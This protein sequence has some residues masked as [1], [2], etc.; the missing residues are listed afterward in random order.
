MTGYAKSGRTENKV[1]IIIV[2]C[3]KIGSTLA[4][5][6]NEVG[7]D[8]VVIDQSPA[9]VKE[10]ASKYDLMGVIGNGATRDTLKEAGVDS[11]HLV[12]AVTGSDELNLLCCVMAKKKSGCAAI[13]RVKNP[14]YS[15]DS[16]YLKEELELGLVIN[17][18]YSA[19]EEIARLLKFPMAINIES[20][21]KGKVDLIRYRLTENSALIG[22]S[23]KEAMIKFRSEVIV[24]TV[25]RGEDVF[26]PK[27]DFVFAEK[28]VISFAATQKSAAAF[29]SK[30]NR[31]KQES[32]KSATIIG[33]GVTTHYLLEL[34][35]RSGIDIKV[36][37]KNP[38]I[39]DE[40]STKFDNVTVICANPSDE[41]VLIEE[42]VLKTDA[43]ISLTDLDEENILLSLFAKNGGSNKVITKINKIEY[44]SVIS[45][46]ELDSI[47]YPKNIASDQIIRYARAK[48]KTIGSSMETLY[49]L[50]PGQVEATEFIVGERSALIG[51]PLLSIKFNENILIASVIRGK[52][53]IVPRGSTALETGDSV[54][55][56]SKGLSLHSLADLTK[57]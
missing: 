6:L 41:K 17:P 23:M 28:D 33:G 43:F 18:E 50:I 26:I 48:R 54:V 37:E 49:N 14:E 30:I 21:S 11:A 51:K 4:G 39:C 12:I 44:D 56:V 20:F 47:I 13:A 35:C 52:Q 46:L 36:I 5:K 7:N 9:K 55:V 31:R 15:G 53:V 2:G 27:G 24:C 3:G 38:E 32:V 42:G 57:R 25:E 10:V 1:K 22:L 16:N 8:V 19:A 40:L 45:K 29:I 34:L